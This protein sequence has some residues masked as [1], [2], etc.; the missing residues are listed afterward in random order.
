MALPILQLGPAPAGWTPSE[1]TVV[2]TIAGGYSWTPQY[3][4][5]G[6][7]KERRGWVKMESM[8]IFKLMI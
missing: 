6:M 7:R 5:V 2:Q 1:E 4:W 8:S 3:K